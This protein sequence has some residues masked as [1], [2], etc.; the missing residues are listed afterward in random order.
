MVF[1]LCLIPE[2][3]ANSLEDLQRELKMR[4]AK[5]EEKSKK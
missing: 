5:L 4:I 3:H 2:A 1:I